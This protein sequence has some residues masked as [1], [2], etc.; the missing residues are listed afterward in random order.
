MEGK[1][2]GCVPSILENQVTNTQAWESRGQWE[3]SGRRLAHTHTHNLSA[4]QSQCC[5]IQLDTF[6]Q[7]TGDRIGKYCIFVY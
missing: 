7:C 4:S 6:A 2:E 3:T 1:K 5:E